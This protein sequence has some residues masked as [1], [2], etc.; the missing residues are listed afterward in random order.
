MT[1]LTLLPMIYFR[2]FWCSSLSSLLPKVLIDCNLIKNQDI[3]SLSRHIMNSIEQ[4]EYNVWNMYI[5]LLLFVSS[6]VILIQIN[7][8]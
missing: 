5:I 8:E 6:L 2:H 4:K 7:G 1:D 3:Y